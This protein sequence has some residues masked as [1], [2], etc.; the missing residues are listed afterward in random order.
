MNLDRQFGPYRPATRS[1]VES[2]RYWTEQTPDSPALYFVDGEGAEQRW[3]YRELTE[4]S[5]TVAA[6]LQEHSLAG[7]RVLL[8]FPPG[9]EFVQGFFG[10]LMAG[11]VAVPA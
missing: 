7:E 8:M 11:A 4:R 6:L 1:I 2:L 10:C 9:L 3:S 5:E